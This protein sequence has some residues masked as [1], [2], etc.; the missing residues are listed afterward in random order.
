MDGT[1]ITKI[2]EENKSL[3]FKNNENS[4]NVTHENKFG[5]V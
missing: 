5:I 1:I 3:L 4:T 2:L